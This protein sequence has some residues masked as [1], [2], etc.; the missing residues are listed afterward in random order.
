MRKRQKSLFPFDQLDFTDPAAAETLLKKRN[1]LLW[2]AVTEPCKRLRQRRARDEEFRD[3]VEKE[4]AWWLHTRIKRCAAE[5]CDQYPN[6]GCRATG[7]EATQF[8]LNIEDQAIV[9]FKKIRFARFKQRLER[10]NAKTETN[11]DL[12]QQR[13]RHGCPDVP[14]LIVGYQLTKEMTDVVIRIC[15]P[16]SRGM[17]FRW[18]YPLE[19]QS[20]VVNGLLARKEVEPPTEQERRRGFIVR[21]R[22]TDSQEHGTE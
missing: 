16:R 5:L 1:P 17:G 11:L 20:D 12:W 13:R 6:F 3:M 14:R 4:A 8:Y 21:H 18:T 2:L 15:Y 19:D 10:S 22:K 7:I 9:V